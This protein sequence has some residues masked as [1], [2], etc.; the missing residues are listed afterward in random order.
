MNKTIDNI[1]T[2]NEIQNRL[3][4]KQRVVYTRYGDGD[5]IAMYPSSVG[6][7]IGGNNKS[8]I[9]E[10]VRDGLINGYNVNDECYL[11]GTVMGVNHPRS[12]GKNVNINNL[13][14][15]KLTNHEKLYS[16][17]A[18]Q[19]LFME[20]PEKFVEFFNLLNKG[21]YIFVC[22]YYHKNLDRYYGELAKHIKIPKFNSP[23]VAEEVVSEILKINPNTY[24]H[25][26]FSAGQ[27]SRIVIG[28]IWDQIDKTILDLG[29]VSDKLI[30]N[31]P[32]KND[33]MIRGHI[34][35]N[36]KL[37]SERL[38]YFEKNIENGNNI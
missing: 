2:V 35:N 38:N 30:F 33:I 18:F 31:T 34:R 26:I 13:N 4:N 1:E 22:Q 9:T 10:K 14:T 25:I 21:R 36:Q 15:V 23:V 28:E 27:A 3:T 16:A 19:E 17:I 6:K 20:K 11:V 5:L 12:M 7:I 24:D 32:I 8:N 29:S 37:I